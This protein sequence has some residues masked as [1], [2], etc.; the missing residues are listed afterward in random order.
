MNARPLNLKHL[1]YF[2]E[3]ARRGS[4][5][6]A[7]RSLFVA[8]QTVSAQ[9]QSLEDAVGQ[10]L[11]E[12][13]GRRL[14]LTPAGH[15]ALEYANAIF[16]LGDELANVLRGGSRP[17]SSVLR[18]GITDSVP[19]LQSVALL[20][21]VIEQHADTLELYC[22]EGTYPELLGLLATGEFDAVVTDT[23]VPANLARS[24]QATTLAE[25]GT[26]LMAA[27][28]LAAQFAH[29]FP[30]RLDGAPILW[31]SAPSSFLSQALQAWFARVEVRP[32]I[33]GRVEDSA[34]LT[35]F[36]ERG[37]GIIAVPTSIEDDVA[38][39]HG[40][41]VIG[42]IGDITQ[43]VFLIRARDRAPHPLA[44]E[45]E[46]RQKVTNPSPMKGRP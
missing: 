3:V 2:A 21:P 18:V 4:V 5:S 12:R 11:F 22:R 35:G 37:L 45:L 30:R 10:P 39:Q 13:A 27:E 38:R 46:A 24:L 41:G 15:T 31:G 34:L 43:S 42:R 36:A 7:A 1:R 17:K 40:L 20:Q 19:K 25:S 44:R 23:A 16:A 9:I 32:Q 6:E 33:V 28:P 29:D 14:I 26:S 8:P